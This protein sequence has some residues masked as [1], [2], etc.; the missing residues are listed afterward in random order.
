MKKLTPEMS[1]INIGLRLYQTNNKIRKHKVATTKLA[2]KMS[3]IIKVDV[4]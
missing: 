4:V 3:S 2:S 1:P